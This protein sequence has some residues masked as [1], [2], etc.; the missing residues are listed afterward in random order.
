METISSRVEKEILEEIE[1]ISKKRGVDRSV[2]IREMLKQ[3]IREF[4]LKEALQL[5]R[6]RK[7]T[8]WRA[9]EMAD[10]TYREILDSLKRYN[11][12]FPVTL[13]EIKHEIKEISIG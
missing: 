7:I 12:P 11:I 2:V 10:V 6:E 4:K 1:R 9:A 3:G 5:L 8:V 13:E